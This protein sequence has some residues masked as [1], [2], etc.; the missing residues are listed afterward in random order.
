MASGTL[1]FRR[2][3]DAWLIA[4]S[5]VNDSA[6]IR[7]HRTQLHAAMLRLRTTS[8][9]KRDRFDFLALAVLISLNVN[10]N[11]ITEADGA[12]RDGRNDELQRIERLAVAAN[13]NRQIVASNVEYE[14]TFI[15]LVLVDGHF[16]HVEMLQDSLQ[17]IDGGIGD[18]VDFLIGQVMLFAMGS[19][20]AKRLFLG[21]LGRLFDLVNHV[22]FS[23]GSIL[24]L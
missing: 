7:R 23:H 4:K 2:G 24:S 9:G 17:R 5:Q 12:R 13:Q 15:A 18:L 6:L 14:F 3:F 10:N 19:I 11:R 16:A 22:L 21:G 8:S 20:A 1:A